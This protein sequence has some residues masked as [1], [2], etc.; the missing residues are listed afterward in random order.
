MASQLASGSS[1][2]LL[3]PVVEYLIDAVNQ[4]G[5]GAMVMSIGI[6]LDLAPNKIVLGYDVITVLG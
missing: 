1:D 6:F 5:L 3:I 4:A 2:R